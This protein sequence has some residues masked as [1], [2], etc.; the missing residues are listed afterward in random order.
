MTNALVIGIGSRE[1]RD[2]SVG[3]E[4]ARRLR[5]RWPD[6]LVLERDGHA[7]SLM[8]SW[9]GADHVILVDAACGCRRPGTVYRFEAEEGPIPARLLRASTHSW[10]VAEAVE[11]ARALDQLPPKL[12]VYAVEGKSFGRG[13]G[14]SPEVE[15]A[16]GDVVERIL[17]DV[18]AECLS[19]ECA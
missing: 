14:L 5:R 7:A 12:T 17:A 9:L 4:V 1:R 13:R 8:E 6:G 3:L 18:G 10:G 2:D 11:L 15:A 19:P 16:A